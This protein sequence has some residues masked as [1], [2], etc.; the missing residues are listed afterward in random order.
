MAELLT[1]ELVPMSQWADNLR[2]RLPKS[3]WDALRHATYAAAHY[4]CEVCGGVG[5]KHPVECH[6]IW[7]YDDPTST[8]KL[9]GLIAL[10]PHCHE[11]KHFGLAQARG[12]GGPALAHLA[13]VNGWPLA[14]AALHVQVAFAT[15]NERS[16]REWTL[17]LGWLDTLDKPV[18]VDAPA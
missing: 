17:D 11:V 12:R 8:Q 9:V 7:E 4:R 2:S 5:R 13:R 1:V 10:C 14:V 16:I 3:K 18:D 15:W 6:E